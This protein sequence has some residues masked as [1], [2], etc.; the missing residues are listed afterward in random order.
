MSIIW[1]L[2]A[3]VWLLLFF[4]SKAKI[5][6]IVA[7]VLLS[8]AMWLEW[9]DYDADLQKLWETW[10]YSESR[11]QNVKDKN[12]NT[13]KLIWE[14]VKAD[15]NCKNFKTKTDAQNMY[16]KCAAEIKKNNPNLNNPLKLDIYWL[17]RD[18]D[19]LVCEHLAN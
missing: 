3:I 19:W 5:V 6:L 1:I 13:I 18:N 11:V 10:S 7:L 16:E 17:D 12:W 15:I 14:C 9:F 2:I 4:W 8:I